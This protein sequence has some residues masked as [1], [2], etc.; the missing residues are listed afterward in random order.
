MSKIRVG[1]IGQ[2][3]SGRDIHGVYLAKDERFRIVAVADEMEGRRQRATQEYGCEA[4]ADYRELLKRNDIDLVVN[5]SF[6]H[7]HVPI[8]LECLRAGR[9]V[10]CEK[11]LAAKARD[12]DRLIAASKKA[13]KVV[14]IFQQSRYAP[15]FQQVRRV[16][17]SGVLGRIVQIS[18][19]FSGAGRRWDWQTLTG[20]NGGNLLNT[21]PHPLDQALVLFG[22]GMPKVTCFMDRTEG[23]FGDA[24]NHVKLI[25]SGEGHP[26]I[27]LEISSCCA[28]PCFIYN[29]YG[30]LGGMKATSSNAEW[31]Y[32]KWAEAPKQELTTVPLS[33][34]DGTPSYPVEQLTWYTETWPKVATEAEK[35]AGYTA[36]A[37][38][39]VDLTQEYYNM[40]HRTLTEGQ[41]LE[42]T[43]EQVRRQI[44]VIERCQRQNPQY[45]TK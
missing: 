6:S 43:P 34:P 3:R 13:G 12:V 26:L 42:I 9:H 39:T 21:G 45:Y 20:Y 25:L 22:E 19:A 35:K 2:G 44:A 8:S 16:I 10:L 18:I 24:E 31:K 1:I 11:P 15:Y 29:V 33:K 5:S 28:Y 37:A 14:A 36:A 38:A 32:F 27:D 30:S 7:L 41:P 40:L 23:C 17:D 4:Y